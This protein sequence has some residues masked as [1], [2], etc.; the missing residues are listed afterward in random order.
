ME[1]GDVSDYDGMGSNKQHI[2]LFSDQDEVLRYTSMIKN[3]VYDVTET[4]IVVP[5]LCD[6]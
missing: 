6:E 3:C 2:S 1:D 5:K 4:T